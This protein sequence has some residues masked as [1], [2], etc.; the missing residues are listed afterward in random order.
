MMHVIELSISEQ[1][2]TGIPNYRLVDKSPMN[3]SIKKKL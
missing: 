2:V 1:T 3:W